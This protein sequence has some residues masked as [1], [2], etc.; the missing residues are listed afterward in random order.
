MRPLSKDT[1]S[2]R[3]SIRL[4]VGARATT[5]TLIATR[6]DNTK[7]DNTDNAS[8]DDFKDKLGRRNRGIKTTAIKARIKDNYIYFRPNVSVTTNLSDS[9]VRKAALKAVI[10]KIKKLTRLKDK[11]TITAAAYAKVNTVIA[12]TT[13]YLS[14]GYYI[15]FAY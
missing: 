10:E 9:T 2:A 15:Y 6:G 13:T 14:D 1:A 8:N 11:A 5:T 12:L 7:E 3:P 4:R